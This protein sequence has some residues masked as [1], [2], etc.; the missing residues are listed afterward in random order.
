MKL[1]KPI[2]LQPPPF[3]MSDGTVKTYP[4]ITITELDVMFLDFCLKKYVT[5]KILPCPKTIT[6]W[7]G[8]EYDAVGD[9]TQKQA[10]ERLMEILGKNPKDILEGLFW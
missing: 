6:L 8:L 3:T 4:P 2:T 5:A 1:K 10:E 9:W 7:E